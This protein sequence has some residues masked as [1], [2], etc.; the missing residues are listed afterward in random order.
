MN[1]FRAKI[2]PLFI[3]A[4]AL[5]FAAEWTASIYRRVRPEITCSHLVHVKEMGMEC[6]TCHLLHTESESG[7]DTVIPEKYLCEKCHRLND[8]G[9]CHKD[10]ISPRVIELTPPRYSPKLGYEVHPGKGFAEGVCPSGVSLSDTTATDCLTGMPL[11][12]DCH[13]VMQSDDK[14]CTLCHISRSVKMP[15]DHAFPAWKFQHGDEARVE[16][17]A[18][19]AMCHE[20]DLCQQCHQGENL[21]PRV[22]PPGYEFIHA[23]EVRTG[24]GECSACHEDRSFCFGCHIERQV[25]P[26]S[27]QLPGWSVKTGPGG[28][29]AAAGRINIET[30]AS[31]HGDDPGDQPVCT[32]CHD[33]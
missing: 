17:A 9:H 23:L 7:R 6:K 11:C 18:R 30:C 2:W 31:C 22:H 21:A 28:R 8:C 12:M 14:A 19:C 32:A 24:R 10:T 3:L 5:L 27:H 4:P 20:R 25:Y 15:T 16:D 33:M 29:H 13:D 1:K 26:R